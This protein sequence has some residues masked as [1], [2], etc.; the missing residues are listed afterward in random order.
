MLVQNVSFLATGEL[1]LIATTVLRWLASHVSTSIL[2]EGVRILVVLVENTIVRVQFLH[3][4]LTGFVFV[5]FSDRNGLSR[6]NYLI[7][8]L[9]IY[10]I[11]FIPTGVLGFWGFGVLL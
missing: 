5:F 3:H 9:I 8:V 6:L 11:V 1:N 7:N 2:H 10:N 4:S